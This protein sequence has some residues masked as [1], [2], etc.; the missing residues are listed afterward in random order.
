M[1]RHLVV[2]PSSRKTSQEAFSFHWSPF[3]ACF[4][5]ILSLTSIVAVGRRNLTRIFYIGYTYTSQLPPY[6]DT[7]PCLR[8]ESHVTTYLTNAHTHTLSL[9]RHSN[10]V[11]P[12]RLLTPAAPICRPPP[13]PFASR[14]IPSMSDVRHVPFRACHQTQHARHHRTTYHVSPQFSP[15]MMMLG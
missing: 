3:L 15:R 11:D 10:P 9:C 5:P 14:L 12:P 4:L 2:R 8:P 6:I 13:L 7:N 1:P